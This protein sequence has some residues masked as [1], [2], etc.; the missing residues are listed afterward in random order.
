MIDQTMTEG[1]FMDI[2]GRELWPMPTDP[3]KRQINNRARI[4]ADVGALFTDAPTQA[5]IRSTA[6][7]G[8]QSVVEYLDHFAP[9]RGKDGDAATTARAERTLVQPAVTTL[10][11]KAFDAFATTS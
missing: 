8:Y 3:G 5:T 10:K 6:W 9:V 11:T 4:L 7:A 1:E 2:I